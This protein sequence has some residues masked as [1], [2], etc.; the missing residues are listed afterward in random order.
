MFANGFKVAFNAGLI[1]TMAFSNMTA[2][3]LAPLPPKVTIAYHPLTGMVR[4][5]GAQSGSPILEATALASKGTPENAARSFL[6]ISGNKF[7]IADASEDLRV[8]RKTQTGSDTSTVRFQQ[9]YQGIPV[10]AG[11]L[12]VQMDSEMNVL[13]ASGDILPN[14]ELDSVPVVEKAVAAQAAL[15]TTAK[16]SSV[17]ID[18]LQASAP[19]LWVYSP[20]L[21]TP[22]NGETVLTWRVE[23]TPK[24]EL[25]PLRQLVLV[26]AKSGGIALSFNQ[27]DYALDRLTYDTAGTNT[28][29]GTLNCN[30]GN[31]TCTGGSA[32]AVNAHK[33]AG[34][35]YDFYMT[36]HA[37]DSLDDAGMSLIST[38]NYDDVP[39]GATYQ[40]AFWNGTQMVYGAGWSNADDIV[41]HE[42]THGV[43][44]YESNLFYYYQSGAINESFS[45]VWGEFIDL[46][47]GMGTDTPGARWQLGEDLSFGVLRSMSDPTLYG[48][49]DKITSV[50]YKTSSVDNGG[51]HSNSSVNNKAAYL[52][53]DGGTFNGKTVTALGITKVA[54]IYYY[55]QSNLLTSGSDYADLYYALQA[56]CAAQIGTAGITGADC[57]EVL[58]AVDAVEMNLQPVAG[59]NPD[60]AACDVAGEYPVNNFYDDMEAGAGNWTSA[61]T[62]GTDHWTYDS[63]YGSFAHSGQHV[64]FGDDYLDEVT[65]T[66]VSMTSSILVPANGKMRFQHAYDFENTYDGGVLEYSINGGTSW[67]DA[68]SLMDGNGYDSVLSTLYGNPL[69]GRQAFTGVSHGYISTRLDLSSLAGQNIMFR[70]RMGLDNGTHK[71]GWWL[72]DVQ[73][74]KCKSPAFA[75]V[76]ASHQHWNDIEILY[77]NGLTAGCSVTP[78]NFCPDQI[79][80]RAQSAVFNLRGNFGISYTPPAAPWDT[81]ADDWSAGAWAERWAE[82]MYSAG[83]TAGCATSPLRY[84]PWDQTPKVQAAVFGLRLKYGNSYVPPAASGTVFFDMTNTAYFGTKWSEQAYADGLLPDCGFDIGSGKPIFCPNDLV[85]RG[86]GAYMIV[87]AKNLSIP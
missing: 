42:L 87:R 54:K 85:S 82:G 56:S 8:L 5:M 45:D 84:C 38:V 2:L 77:A 86:L 59:F 58:D 40:N 83:L 57:Q 64:L 53:V 65:D 66:D 75:D 27:V 78:L 6:K 21:L 36:N 28:L 18:D 10:L 30:E 71:K 20:A 25:L 80:D 33:Y 52:M 61:A 55:A 17:N 4:F 60:V 23:V 43:T 14:I 35:T 50:H 13:S 34:A 41:G 16:E 48:D 76:S 81:F 70:W 7:G 32:D 39:G 24:T 63:G 31:P 67:I 44:Q 68:G 22:Y 9:S 12:I 1:I 62:T 49:P 47:D 3:A 11:E 69:G 73:I 46:S 15:E 19:E 29:P 51:V 74:Y 79:M 37:R 26:D 72:D